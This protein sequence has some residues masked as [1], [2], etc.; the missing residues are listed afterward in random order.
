[1]AVLAQAVAAG[2]KAKYL[3]DGDPDLASIRPDPRF[4]KIVESL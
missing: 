3:L 4:K 1:M 2:F